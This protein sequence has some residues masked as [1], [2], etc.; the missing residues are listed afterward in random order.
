MI[1]RQIE[2]GFEVIGAISEEICGIVASNR[3]NLQ[4]HHVVFCGKRLYFTILH[5]SGYRR[6]LKKATIH[7][8]LRGLVPF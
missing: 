3:P 4:C 5:S 1:R 7:A 6:M 8:S 2:D